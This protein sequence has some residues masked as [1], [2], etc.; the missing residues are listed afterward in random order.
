MTGQYDNVFSVIRAS[1]NPCDLAS[2]SFVLLD[3]EARMRDQ[4]FDH[5]VSANVAVVPKNNTYCASSLTLAS[6]TPSLSQA[7]PQISAHQGTQSS[8]TQ[9]SLNL[10]C[11]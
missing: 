2:M 1:I 3:V 7:Q 9:Q 4:L 8:S 11:A 5:T 10:F 6:Q